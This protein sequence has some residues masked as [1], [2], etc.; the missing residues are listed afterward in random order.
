MNANELHEKVLYPVVRVRTNKAGGSGTVIYSQP[1]PGN[2]GEYLSFVLTNW[3]VVREAITQ[4]KEWDSLLRRDVKKDVLTQVSVEVFDYVRLSEMNSANTFRADIIAYDK[5]HDLAILKLDSPREVGHV[6]KLIDRAESDKVKLFTPVW[7]CGCS[8]GHDPFATD[9]YITFLKED[10]DNRQYWM[11]NADQIF[12]NSGGAVFHAQ[13]GE[14]L[15]VTARVTIS[16]LGF[17]LD[18]QTWMNFC[19]PAWRI[20]D[21]LEEQELNFLYDDSDTYAEALGRRKEAWEQAR[22]EALRSDD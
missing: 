4:V 2:E 15:G 18:V 13:T 14:Q 12:G 9:G 11:N 22:K 21:F 16:Q 17:S 10:I 5:N 19:I 1:D 3:H 20:Y 7:A 8:L 6:A